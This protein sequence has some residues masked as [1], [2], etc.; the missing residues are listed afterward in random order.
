MSENVRENVAQSSETGNRFRLRKMSFNK[1]LFC[2]ILLRNIEDYK[3]LGYDTTLLEKIYE[4][5]C[6]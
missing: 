4:S 1:K 2:E 3:R 6:S 5:R